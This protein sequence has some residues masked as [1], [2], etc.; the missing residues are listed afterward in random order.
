MKK[1][2]ESKSEDH[3]GNSS[4]QIY[5]TIYETLASGFIADELPQDLTTRFLEA[6]QI[7]RS[8][9]FSGLQ[10]DTP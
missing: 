1:E 6:V 2:E 9:V 3:F 8:D 10:N 7:S 4:L 5:E